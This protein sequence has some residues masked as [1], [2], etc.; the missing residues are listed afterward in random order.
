MR[1]TA[2]LLLLGIAVVHAQDVR[3]PLDAA[4][5][6]LRAPEAKERARAARALGRLDGDRAAAALREA[7]EDEA[8][9]V[10]LAAAAAL[11]EQGRTGEVLV[12]VLGA[13]LRSDDWYTRWQACLALGRM[14]P[15]ARSA[16]P[17]L[18]DAAL[19][20]HRDVTREATLA[21]LRIDPKGRAV[22]EAFVQLLGSGRGCEPGLLLDHLDLD[23]KGVVAWLKTEVESDAHRL[24]ERA[25][26]LLG[27]AGPE[28]VLVLYYAT[29]SEDAEV[30]RLANQGLWR[31]RKVRAAWLAPDLIRSFREGNVDR[32]RAE[33]Y[34]LGYQHY[35]VSAL[36]AR[37]HRVEKG[38]LALVGMHELRVRLLIPDGGQTHAL[39]AIAEELEDK[40][41]GPDLVDALRVVLDE[42][43][44]EDWCAQ[45]VA[46]TKEQQICA[47]VLLGLLARDAPN[48]LPLLEDAARSD[49]APLKAAA[50]RAIERLEERE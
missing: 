14:G 48:A 2:M 26:D 7:L 21:L 44:E 38:P 18:A 43:S 5:A 1:R 6:R 11:V 9:P 17:A 27:K 16:T 12:T 37:W 24:R 45:L 41:R 13:C 35:L 33:L 15:A 40:L 47:A 23:T 49:H 29:A 46:G 4:L 34:A 32:A 20:E 25:S 39:R 3:D 28:G 31:A 50:T 36:D 22:Q 10:R 30:R 42:S 19:D 8:E